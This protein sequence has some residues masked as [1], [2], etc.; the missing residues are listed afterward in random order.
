VHPGGDEPAG[1]ILD[2]D[3]EANLAEYR[4]GQRVSR[5]CRF[6]ATLVASLR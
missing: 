2:D 6:D 3:R 5:C 1:R 4:R